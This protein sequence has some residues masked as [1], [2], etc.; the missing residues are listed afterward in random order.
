MI[1]S[2]KKEDDVKRYGDAILF[3]YKIGRVKEAMVLNDLAI[4][5]FPNMFVFR[6]NKN[7]IFSEQHRSA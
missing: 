7:T 6:K 4:K 1:E 3:I 5:K 2:L